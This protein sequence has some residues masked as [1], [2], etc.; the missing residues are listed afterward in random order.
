MSA[1]LTRLKQLESG[2]NIQDTPS[3]EPPKP[4]KA[5]FDGFAGSHPGHIEN[6]FANTTALP[7]HEL[8]RLVRLV[9]DHHGF[10]QGDYNEAL[11]IALGDQVSTLTCFSALARQAGLI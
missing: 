9:S 8:R 5:P 7:E 4:P 6:I 10:T 3:I 2:E 11:E 1:Y